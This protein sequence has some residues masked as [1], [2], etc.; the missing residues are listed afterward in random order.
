MKN[1]FS[2]F[3][4]LLLSSFL[5]MDTFGQSFYTGGIGITQSNGG[6][7][8]IFSDNLTTRQF[9]R[10]SILVGVS[11]LAVFDYNEDQDVL[12]NAATVA[13]PLL[14][15]F[16]ITSTINN[17][18]SGLPPVVQASYNFY[19]WNN[20]A[21]LLVKATVKNNETTAINAVIGLEA[22]PRINGTYENDTLQWDAASS[23]VLVHKNAWAGIKFLSS[24]QKSLR[25]IDWTS[26]YAND[27]L[28]YTWLTQNSF[29]PL[30]IANA[31][32]DG[33]VAILGQDPVSI[34]P[35]DSA[36]FYFGISIG[37]S[38]TSCLDNMNL[39][40]TK[41]NLI[42][43]VELT[44]FTGNVQNNKVYLNWTTATELN[45][46]GFEVERKSDGNNWTIIGFKEGNGTTSQMEN[47]SFVDDL[48]NSKSSV[49]SYR[50][51]Q[52]DFNG[53]FAYSNEIEVSNNIVPDQFILEQ[54]YPNPFN[55]GTKITFRLPEKSNVVVKVFNNLG[56]EVAVVANG[57]FNEGTYNYY[58]DAS[59]LSSGNYIYTLQTESGTIAKKM[60]LLK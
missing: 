26:S 5:M 59:N 49:I 32:G 25:L 44:S 52:I 57:Y 12:V 53:T 56:E 15:D 55:P 20:G 36:I 6:R 30:L 21:Y 37:D 46:R 35:G 24:Q 50:L 28:Y 51:K 14:S 19:G 2:Y 3:V 7:T 17:S 13:S 48:S 23:T 22:I 29:D 10:I 16:E 9:E 27:S 4:V 47:Y 1:I 38:K 58:F 34:N 45:N 33:A 18:Y 40:Q 41:Y 43:P 11:T 54:N 42:L 60:T 8:R 31:V 39:C